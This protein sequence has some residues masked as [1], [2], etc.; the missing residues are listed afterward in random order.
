MLFGSEN[1]LTPDSLREVKCK[2]VCQNCTKVVI[3]SD[4]P[5]VPESQRY[6]CEWKNI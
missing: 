1:V 5:G 3:F 2:K 4:V 6:L